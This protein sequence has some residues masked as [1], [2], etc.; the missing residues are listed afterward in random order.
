MLGATNGGADVTVAI[1]V[2][3]WLAS[4][5]VAVPLGRRRHRRGLVYGVFLGWFGVALLLL[6]PPG[7]PHEDVLGAAWDE[8]R[9]P[10]NEPFFQNQQYYSKH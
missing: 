9:V 10:T 8:T 3:A 7:H 4:V 5:V 6:L 2:L 1:V